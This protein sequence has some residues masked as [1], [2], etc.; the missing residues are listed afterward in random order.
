M[1]AMR[2]L[3]VCQL[4]IVAGIVALLGTAA[5][6]QEADDVLPVLGEQVED[7]PGLADETQEIEEIIV[8]APRPGARRRIDPIY[9]D[10]MRARLLKEL[11]EMERIDEEMAWRQSGTD[12]SSSRIKWGYDPQDDYRIRSE[13][14][15]ND[16]QL[17][18]TRPATLFRVEF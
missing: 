12:D 8:V 13:M 15:I 1:S 16:T 9:E 2:S 6:A 5:F 7:L 14:E 18:N 4:G 11:Y 17:G 3:I 10:P